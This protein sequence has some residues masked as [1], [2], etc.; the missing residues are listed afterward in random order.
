MPLMKS[1]VR[2]V[3]K[4]LQIKQDILLLFNFLMNFYFVYVSLWDTEHAQKVKMLCVKGN[5]I[6]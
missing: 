4:Q 6:E 5:L 3:G 1:Q 2:N